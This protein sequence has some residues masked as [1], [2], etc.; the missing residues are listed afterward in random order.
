MSAK[1]WAAVLCLVAGVP[2]AAYGLASGAPL[3]ALAGL[4]LV[5][6]AVA[7]IGRW[8][9]GANKP[10][11]PVVPAADAAWRMKDEPPPGAPRQ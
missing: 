7:L 9:A 10:Q 11:R 4:A 3:P 5:L 2:L 6:A 1:S 8:I